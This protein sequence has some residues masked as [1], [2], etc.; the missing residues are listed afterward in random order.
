[1]K[2]ILLAT[3][4]AAV[5]STSSA[6]AAEGDFYVKA[7]AGW[8]N[9]LKNKT[10]EIK[11]IKSLGTLK[12]KTSNTAFFGVGVG[13]NIMDNARVD[14]TFDHFFNAQQKGSI[15][16]TVNLEGVDVDVAGGFKVK[17]EINTLL[18]N[19]YVDIFDVSVAKIF[20]GAGVGASHVKSKFSASGELSVGGVTHPYNE[21]KK[22]KGKMNFAYAL[23]VGAGVEVAPGVY[24]ELA[25]SFRDLGK[26][27]V[28]KDN[29]RT[30][31]VAAG[32]RFNL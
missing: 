22:I 13:Y 17:N 6:Y 16:K 31:N 7:N 12:T 24:G 9:L 8:S 18:L 32:V 11:E 21:S 28:L 19:G 30:H 10:K 15:N 23:H 5:I 27:K 20:V 14:L 26:T 2:K 29:L 4:A 1:M 3:A 25:Y